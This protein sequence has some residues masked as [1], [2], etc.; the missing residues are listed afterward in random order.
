M[1]VNC[2]PPHRSF[3]GQVAGA[4]VA[5]CL[6]VTGCQT[7]PFEHVNN[8]TAFNAN[9]MPTTADRADGSTAG[10]TAGS[11]ST[12]AAATT[13]AGESTTPAS[14]PSTGGNEAA[15]VENLNLGHREAALNRLE[16]AEAYYRRVLELQPDNPVANHRLAVLADKQ[17]DYARAEH[18]YMTALRRE[19]RDPDLLSDLGYSYLLQGRRQDSERCLNAATQLDPSHAKALHN[20]SLLFAMNGDYDRSFD[21][22][23]RADGESEA[24]AKIAR[25]F[26]QGRP[27][28]SDNQAMVAS[29]QPMSA[30][31]A[32]PAPGNGAEA[33]S[34]ASQPAATTAAASTSAAPPSANPRG[35]NGRIPDSEINDR[36]AA[37][38]HETEPTPPST[39]TSQ[40]AAT[41]PPQP[42]AAA[43]GFN[44]APVQAAPGADPMASMPLWSPGGSSSQTRKTPAAFEFGDAPSAPTQPQTADPQRPRV[45]ATDITPAED[46]TKSPTILSRRDALSAFDAELQKEKV[47]SG[48][49]SESNGAAT[50]GP[51][52]VDRTQDPT[53]NAGDPQKPV[54]GVSDPAPFNATPPIRIQPR[55]APAPL[56]EP[57]DDFG[58]GNDFAPGDKVS[59]PAWPGTN[60]TTAA[61]AGNAADAGPTI[62]PG[63]P[64]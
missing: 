22:L 59:V 25:L 31:G 16:Q 43:N 34:P 47:A 56:F 40:P 63:S 52:S 15:I 58:P 54:A 44:S 37:I 8:S 17:H 18:Y 28:A 4:L 42:A 32:Q 64:N 12:T 35:L 7:A 13:V 46:A 10:P 29:F 11:P 39:S 6:F 3:M 36:F 61:P 49:R 19:P 57:L 60:G 30:E 27:Q 20:L 38:D 14:V 41:N 9:H 45:V 48:G 55:S 5:G 51:L 62:R 2:R 1:R 26:P 23:R 33:T 50:R 24:R 21:A 53:S